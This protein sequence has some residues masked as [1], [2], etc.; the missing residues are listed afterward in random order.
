MLDPTLPSDRGL[1]VGNKNTVLLALVAFLAICL[2]ALGCSQRDSEETPKPQKV[3]VKIER[4]PEPVE[5]LNQEEKGEEQEAPDVKNT[6][7]VQAKEGPQAMQGPAPTEPV[8]IE[9]APE[10]AQHEGETQE[11]TRALQTQ[12][13]EGW[14]LVT[15][16][17]TLIIV[18]GSSQVYSDPYK[19]PGLLRLNLDKLE[20]SGLTPGLE[21][22]EL[23]PGM[24][25]R[26][27]TPREVE[28]RRTELRGHKWVVNIL[29]DKNSKRISE[30]A[31]KLLKGGIPVYIAKAEIKGE[32]W[33]R[34]RTG[35]FASAAEAK[36]MKDKIEETMGLRGLWVAKISDQEFQK[37]AG[38]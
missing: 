13:K 15:G 4:P 9:T 22:R 26:Y 33:L 28:Q 19:W 24:R 12:N 21:A 17:D 1:T 5:S 18:A 3:V 20:S 27:L 37:Y 29:S 11:D 2:A 10:P 34:L 30:L 25:L 38:Y 23:P 16:Q 32:Q 35:F 6:A 36:K 7:M 14:Y 8:S 31:L